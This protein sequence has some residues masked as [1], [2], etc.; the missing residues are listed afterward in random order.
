LRRT[1]KGKPKASGFVAAET[2]MEDSSKTR[3]YFSDKYQEHE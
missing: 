3:T 2:R 1:M